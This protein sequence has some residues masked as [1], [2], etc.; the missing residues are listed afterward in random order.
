MKPNKLV[1]LLPLIFNSLK[2]FGQAPPPPDCVVNFNSASMAANSGAS[3]TFDNRSV[4]CLFWTLDYQATIT[5]GTVSLAFQSA[6]GAVTAGAFGAYG[7]TTVIG[8]NP[9]T[10]NTGGVSLFANGTVATPWL[11]VTLNTGGIT[12]TVNG[13]LY[14]YKS[15]YPGSGGSTGPSTNVNIQEVAGTSTVTGGVAGTLGVGGPT[16]T[17]S[18]LAARPV[19]VGGSDGT[20]VRNISTDTS[21]RPNVNINGTVPVSGTVTVQQATAASLNATVVGAGTAGT[22]NAGVVTIQGIASMTP[23][24][25]SLSA[26]S[27]QVQGTV[28]DAGSSTGDNPILAAVTGPASTVRSVYSPSTNVDGANGNNMGSQGVY[29]FNGATYNRDFVCTGRA[30]ITVTAGTEAVIIP[31]S[32]STIT[33]ICYIQ[34]SSDVA[35][36]VTIRQGTGTTCQ[37]NTVVLSGVLQSVLAVDSNYG[38]DS[39][40][41][42]TVGGRDV[43]LLFSTAVTAGGAVIYAQY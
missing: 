23:V 34:F 8:S 4:A 39:P 37:T 24:A 42:T 9:I 7:G 12:G 29:K 32:G 10:S 31:L 16:A 11:R 22:A 5:V 13:V 30:T 40:L 20:N 18:P 21:G 27:N 17:G 14:G 41:S 36:N 28:A 38:S 3:A 35:A 26:A 2:V 1:L 15:G 43:C 33:R 6:A 19:L 25:V